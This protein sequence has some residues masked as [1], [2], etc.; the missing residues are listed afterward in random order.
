LQHYEIRLPSGNFAGVIS[1]S[2]EEETRQLQGFCGIV[3]IVSDL[4]KGFILLDRGQIIA[5]YFRDDTGDFV[6]L[7][8]ERRIDALPMD[9][10]MIYKLALWSYNQNE[11]DEALNQCSRER[12][13]LKGEKPGE[14][15]GSGRT[16]GES[17]LNRLLKQPGVLAVCAFNDGFSVQ[18]IGVADP[19]Q[20]A[21]VAEDLFRAASRVVEELRT[22][23]LDQII[24]ESGKRKLIVIPHKDLH[25][26]VLTRNNANLGLI[27]IALR[28]LQY[29]ED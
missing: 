16:F 8:A 26:A 23:G 27:R 24:L 7:D 10:W 4:I 3:E 1:P 6:G 18:S 17:G 29:R 28:N 13:L 21:A 20:L 2:I 19:D 22:G 15:P 11:L 25:I 9:V 12:L 5:A 14:V